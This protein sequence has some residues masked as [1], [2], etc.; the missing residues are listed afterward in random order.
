MSASA[1]GEDGSGEQAPALRPPP[2][3]ELA[4][5][6]ALGDYERAAAVEC[7]AALRVEITLVERASGRHEPEIASRAMTRLAI[8][9]GQRGNMDDAIA[10]LN[11]EARIA[12][13]LSEQLSGQDCNPAERARLEKC[14]VRPEREEMY[15]SVRETVRNELF[16]LFGIWIGLSLMA[17]RPPARLSSRLPALLAMGLLPHSCAMSSY[18]YLGSS[19]HVRERLKSEIREL[20]KRKTKKSAASDAA[21]APASVADRRERLLNAL[22]QVDLVLQREARTILI[23][24]L[25]GEPCQMSMQ[26][27]DPH[28]DGVL[29]RFRGEEGF[30]GADCHSP[31][32]MAFNHLL[33]KL[34]QNNFPAQ[35]WRPAICDRYTTPFTGTHFHTHLSAQVLVRQGAGGGGEQAQ[36]AWRT[37]YVNPHNFG[38]RATAVLDNTADARCLD[39]AGNAGNPV[40]DEMYGILVHALRGSP[41]GHCS[42]APPS[43]S[44]SAH[45]AAS[46]VADVAFAPAR[47]DSTVTPHSAWMSPASESSE[48]AAPARSDA[49]AAG[50]SSDGGHDETAHGNHPPVVVLPDFLEQ[51]EAAERGGGGNSTPAHAHTEDSSSCEASPTQ[52]HVYSDTYTDEALQYALANRAGQRLSSPEGQ[53]AA[54]C[55]R[56][57]EIVRLF[58]DEDE[59][60]ASASRAA[61]GVGSGGV[62]V[63]AA[64]ALEDEDIYLDAGEAGGARTQPPEALDPHDPSDAAD[65]LNLPPELPGAADAKDDTNICPATLARWREWRSSLTAKAVCAALAILVLA[66]VA[67]LVALSISRASTPPSS[68]PAPASAL[69]PAVSEAGDLG[70]TVRMTLMLPLTLTA[71][72]D[73]IRAALRAA[74]A[75]AAGPR[76]NAAQV[77]IVSVLEGPRHVHSIYLLACICTYIYLY[78]CMCK[79][80]YAHTPAHTRTRPLTRTHT[81]AYTAVE[82]E[83]SSAGTGARTQRASTA[84]DRTQGSVTARQESTKVSFS[85]VSLHP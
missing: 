18:A 32:R 19:L 7:S 67:T 4:A 2:A 33:K 69:A 75:A 66:L 79:H 65:A 64:M 48:G 74:V 1:V 59:L 46:V 62:A 5:A 42:I 52:G 40:M 47:S 85:L 61:A 21:A 28:P 63:Q 55:G 77:T 12:K 25:W 82:R 76:V 81:H 36:P 38:Q 20:K 22:N 23:L 41:A 24:K 73:E 83:Q 72:T 29:I 34:Q 57:E 56:D 27:Q 8:A 37:T 58:E 16:D 35:S 11:A 43:D 68:T 10:M 13:G 6:L 71:F 84:L 50:A 31:V 9:L 60:Q 14:L 51:F 44:I 70:A 26:G 39:S 3:S 17:A 49:G 80:T 30:N 45:S 78:V 54:H 53:V 15:D